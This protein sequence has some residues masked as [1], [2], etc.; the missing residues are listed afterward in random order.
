MSALLRKRR[1]QTHERLDQELGDPRPPP[2]GGAVACCLAGAAIP[3]LSSSASRRLSWR[4][5]RKHRS[6][7]HQA[8]LWNLLGDPSGRQ[9]D[10]FSFH[11][12]SHSS[13]GIPGKR[14]V[15]SARAPRKRWYAWCRPPHPQAALCSSRGREAGLGQATSAGVPVSIRGRL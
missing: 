3:A 10:T 11:P 9:T 4:L 1:L 2:R 6:P 15:S 8:S 5:L 14:R 12:P 13:S 7:A